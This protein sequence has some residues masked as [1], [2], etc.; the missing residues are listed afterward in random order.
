MPLAVNFDLGER[1]GQS[2]LVLHV[3]E[4]EGS[5]HE[6]FSV[7][8]AKASAHF[9]VGQDGL[10]EQY[11][12]VHDRAWGQRAGNGAWSSVETSGF[13]A[14]PLTEAQLEAVARIYTWG[15]EAHGWPLA[16]SDRPDQP[17]LGTH[18]MGGAP[19]GNHAC[20]GSLRT[21]QRTEIIR[22]AAAAAAVAGGP[23]RR[24]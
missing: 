19:W 1:E 12:S 15:V 3:Q 4:G 18:E 8:G 14:R 7:P 9:W 22:R 13:K 17:G 23:G 20:P 24:P 6:Q 10:T 16:V 5:L 11:V 2:G 21:A